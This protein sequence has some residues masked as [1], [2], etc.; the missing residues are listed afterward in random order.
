MVLCLG[1]SETVLLSH[2]RQI[3]ATAMRHF[4]R[5]ADALTQGGMRIDGFTNVNRVSAHLDGQRNLPNHV[6]CMGVAHRTTNQTRTEAL[7]F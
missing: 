4:R 3:R 7:C 6:A 5:H 1:G 2:R